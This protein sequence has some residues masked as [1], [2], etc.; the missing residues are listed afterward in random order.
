VTT[1][2]T[3]VDVDGRYQDVRIGA[4]HVQAVGQLDPLPSDEVV[5]GDGGALLPGLHDHHLH[6]L[7]L[8]AAEASV[9]VTEGLEPLSHLSGGG[10]VRA[11]GWSGEG[12]RHELDRALAHRPLR[13]QHRSGALWVLNSAA[14]Q[15]LGLDDVALPG[16]ERDADGRPTGRLWRLDSWLGERLG[17]QAPDLPALGLRLA[18]LGITGVTDATSDLEPETC[19]LLRAEVP[20]HLLLLGDPLG[21]G[22]V[23][24]VLADHALPTLDELVERISRARPRPVA[25]HCV[26]RVALVLLLAAWDVVGRHPGDRVEHAGVVPPE[27][28]TDLPL[29]VTQPAMACARGDEYLRDVAVEDQ[30]H[31]Y[32]Y[33]DLLAGG[34]AVVPSSDAPYGPVDPWEVLRAARDRRTPSGRRLP[35][36]TVPVALALDGM[37][38]PLEDPRQP[39]RSVRAGAAADLVL[40]TVP[41]REALTEPSRELVRATWVDGEQ[42][43]G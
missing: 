33:G 5:R 37:L 8:A 4:G 26:T 43:A 35:G 23:K 18:A 42:V 17:H 32:P 28:A 40:L 22:P 20:Q 39:A 38:R 34:V 11:V 9:D 41:L 29:C 7:A 14:V 19:A 2:F 6:L 13:V 36:G 1:L 15:L 3:D 21:D 27:L 10:W 25:V 16:V 12:D 24:V 31:L 30:A